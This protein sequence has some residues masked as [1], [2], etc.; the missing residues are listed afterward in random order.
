MRSL[1]LLFSALSYVF[2]QVDPTWSYCG[3]QGIY[4]CRY[5]QTCCMDLQKRTVSGYI[6]YPKENAVCCSDGNACPNN[7]TC[8][9]VNKKC[10]SKL[11]GFYDYNR[12]EVFEPT[13]NQ[14][15]F[16][17]FLNGVN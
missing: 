5:D 7:T 6:C 14:Q 16:L 17:Q 3:T 11:W 9:T 13:K 12:I 1:F 2:S 15:S 8:D 10:V 4:R